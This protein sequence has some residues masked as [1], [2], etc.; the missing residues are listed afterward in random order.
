M[1]YS[2]RLPRVNRRA[3]SYITF[4]SV[5]FAVTWAIVL[6][7]IAPGWAYDLDIFLRAARGTDLTGYFYAPW[8]LHI[9]QLLLPLP[10]ELIHISIS[11]LNIFGLLL[12][13]K[14]FK[15]SIPVVM[16]SYPLMFSIFYGQPD[17]LWAI[18]LALMFWGIKRKS[19][20]L[21]VF[22]WI[23]AL[24]K[25]YIGVPLGIGLLW[26]FSDFRQ[27][28]LI[29]LFTIL[30][31][32]GTLFIYGPWPL[33]ILERWKMVPPEV[34]YAIDTWQFVGP[35]AVLV[36]IPYLLIRNRSYSGFVAAWALSS[37]YV[38]THGLTHLL[39]TVGPV[40]L[41]TDLGYILGHGTH[42]VILQITSVIVYLM[43]FHP[44]WQQRQAANADKTESPPTE[45]ESEVASSS[46]ASVN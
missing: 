46:L 11:L 43:A 3:M 28:R 7:F 37:P 23:I 39:V 40:G 10:Y 38:N 20:P 15:G 44:W 35:L 25:Y 45:S 6:P 34:T 31:L 36:W 29:I 26:C 41:L 22:G 9:Y 5:V 42:L 18:G 27:A 1:L 2:L 8:G 24:A 16:T 32:I 19:T 14:A 13:C 17:G 21:A 30:S 4:A 33:E 12:A